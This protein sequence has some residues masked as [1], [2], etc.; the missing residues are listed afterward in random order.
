MAGVATKVR[1]RRFGPYVL[2]RRIGSGGMAT[3]YAARQVG[4]RGATRVVAL[5]VMATALA[6]DPAAQQMFAR[7]AVIAT[8]VEHPN[9]VRT[10]EVGEVSG[11][12]FLAMELVQGA[13]LSTICA[14][15]PGGVPIPIAVR[16][17]A[18]IARGLH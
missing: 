16:I 2:G 5:K 7:E 13:A 12:I 3:V 18:D 1:V 6:D 17:A 4:A 15:A 9:I 14:R 10:Y 8:R 11:E